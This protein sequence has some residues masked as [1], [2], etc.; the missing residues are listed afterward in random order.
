MGKITDMKQ[1]YTAETVGRLESIPNA[2]RRL[3]LSEEL[4]L[5]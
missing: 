4:I 5:W 2:A 3:T 1:R